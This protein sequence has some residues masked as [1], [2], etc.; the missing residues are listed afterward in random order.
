MKNRHHFKF[1]H[2]DVHYDIFEKSLTFSGGEVLVKLNENHVFW[3]YI[4]S[5]PGK[6][7]LIAQIQS[8]DELMALLLLKD[9]FDR[10]SGG[11]Q[12]HLVL[13][14]VPYARQDRVCSE[15]ES[16]SLKVFCE[17]IN[18]C[19]FRTVT[20]LDPHSAVTEALLDNLT[21]IDQVSL[22]NQNKAFIHHYENLPGGIFWVSPD[23]GANKKTAEI[24]KYFGCSR[25]LRADKLRD[26]ATGKIL[27]TIVYAD[28]L[29]GLTCFIADDICDGGRTFVELAKALKTKGAARVELVVTHGI[30]SQGIGN[31]LDN[32]ID[33]IWTT[34]S[35]N[36]T[37]KNPPRDQDYGR[38]NVLPIIDKA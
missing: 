22:I 5:I 17:L 28:S 25:F 18:R 27:E 37:D 34:D 16:H 13:P 10:L 19:E 7:K 8:S 4:H 23:A 2:N 3:Q 33:F 24:A 11:K 9:A 30:F 15:G 26:M 29:K 12:L 21:V 32:G 14:Y 36:F 31:L 1:Y 20:V 35:F 38:F 6:T